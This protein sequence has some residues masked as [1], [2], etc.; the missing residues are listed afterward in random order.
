[1]S[2]AVAPLSQTLER[3]YAR[4]AAGVR[5]GLAAIQALLEVLDHPETQFL[6]V[7]V[8]GTNGKGSVCSLIESTFRSFG[9]KTGLFTS[10]HLVRFNER[11][12]VNGEIISDEVLEPILETIDAADIEMVKRGG[13]RPCTFFELSTAIAFQYFAESEVH[14][15]IIETGVGGTWDSTNVV[16]PLVS[17]I[18][19]IGMD[20]MNFLGNDL[21]SIAGEK[22]GIIKPGRPVVS[23]RQENAEVDGVIQ[24]AAER[25]PAAYLRFA[26]DVSI[27][28][29]SIQLEGQK[30]LM[31]SPNASYG[32][33][34]ISLLGTHQ[35]ENVAL[36]TAAVEVAFDQLGIEL[37]IQAVKEGVASASWPAR[38]QVVQMDPCVIIDG[39]HNP[40]GAAALASTL[41]QLFAGKKGAFVLG[42]LEGKA[43]DEMLASWKPLIGQAWGVQVQSPRSLTL[44]AMQTQFRNASIAATMCDL[45]HALEEAQAYAVT[46]DT[47]VCVAGSLY[48]AGETMD[49]LGNAL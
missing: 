25:T 8:A 20:H 38:C 28:L 16:T 21:L 32:S 4:T 49:L 22:C 30:F 42:C 31:E 14:L 18:T 47:Y 36:A 19:R 15:A 24:A 12:R 13:P 11:F 43:F 34:T 7:H 9:F 26:D 40:S 3:I 23:T 39:A 44:E 5:P 45:S 1:M 46:H 33:C 17:V 6:V 2:E 27:H 48:M 41:K 10:P 37:P 29:N 35:L